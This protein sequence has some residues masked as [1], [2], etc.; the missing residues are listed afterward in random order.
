MT[1]T[2]NIGRILNSILP[3]KPIFRL[4]FPP[5]NTISKHLLN[6]LYQCK[7]KINQNFHTFV[8]VRVYTFI[9]IRKTK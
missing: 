7:T 3:F 5:D 2:Q 4:S 9:F 1:Y 8:C 6:E